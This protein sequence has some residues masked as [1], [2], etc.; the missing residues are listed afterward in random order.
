MIIDQ[1]ELSEILNRL[2]KK[3]GL[4][5]TEEITIKELCKKVNNQNLCYG[6]ENKEIN[7][8]RPNFK[9]AFFVK[10]AYLEY[11]NKGKTGDNFDHDYI[12]GIKMLNKNEIQLKDINNK[13]YNLEYDGENVRVMIPNGIP[14]DLYFKLIN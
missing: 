14:L 3:V 1:E 12:T 10:N 8:L 11:S 9:N 4:Q 13:K 5:I 7:I 6:S 2:A